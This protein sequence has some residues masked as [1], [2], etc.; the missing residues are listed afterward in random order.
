MDDRNSKPSLSRG[1]STNTGLGSMRGSGGMQFMKKEKPPKEPKPVK[2]KPVKEKPVKEKPVKEKPVK[3][4][5]VKEKGGGLFGIKKK[6]AIPEG[7][8]DIKAE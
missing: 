1:S 2:E 6:T 5:K 8:A 3:Q 4:P 7:N